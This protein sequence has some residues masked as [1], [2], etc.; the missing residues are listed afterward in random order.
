MYCTDRHEASHGRC[1]T[2]GRTDGRTNG[3]TRIIM[4]RLFPR[5]RAFFMMNGAGFRR[6]WIT[7]YH[8][9]L[10]LTT[11]LRRCWKQTQSPR[12]LR[13]S[14]IPFDA[15]GHFT[16]WISLSLNLNTSIGLRSQAS[17]SRLN[18]SGYLHA[19]KY[20]LLFLFIIILLLIIIII[21]K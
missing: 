17:M 13:L 16:F 4:Q 15:T 7:C 19:L 10:A 2:H 11:D 18:Y 20:L 8:L 12:S 6:G 9:W 3:R 21:L 1:A 5:W 14:M